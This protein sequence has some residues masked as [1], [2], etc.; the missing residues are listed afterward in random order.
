MTYKLNSLKTF[1][2]RWVFICIG[3]IIALFIM[4]LPLCWGKSE[5]EEVEEK[6]FVS[7]YGCSHYDADTNSCIEWDKW[8]KRCEAGFPTDTLDERWY[9]W[10]LNSSW[11][12]QIMPPIDKHGSHER[13]K[14]LSLAYGINPSLVWEVENQYN[15]REWVTLCLIISETSGWKFWYGRDGCWNFW[16][17]G[18][19]DRWD[20]RCY[21]SEREWLMAVGK[22]LSNK[23]LWRIQT[24][25]C[26]SNAGSC[27]WW[28]DL[29]SRYAT[30]EWNWERTMLNCLN[31]IY[32][33]ELWEIDPKRFNVRRVYTI[34]Q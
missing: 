6:P 26:L 13:F 28:E 27:T 30:S 11:D 16:N 21:S 29:T 20:R 23:Y 3:M 7:C 18:N 9:P 14:E 33:E 1:K 31:T 34:Y 2:D 25:W 22:A 17:V 5:V 4:L 10:E 32:S 19:N 15:I 8:S 24:L 12:A